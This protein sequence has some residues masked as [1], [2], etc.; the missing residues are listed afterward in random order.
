MQNLY[1]TDYGHYGPKI[2]FAWNPNYFENK[3]VVRGGFASAYN[4]L[5][6]SLFENTVENGPGV[7]QFTPCCGTSTQ[8]FGTPFAGGQ[9]SYV[10]GS[11]SNLNSFKPNPAFTTG[12]AASGFP[13]SAPG[14]TAVPIELYGVG[15]KIR[16]PIS[17]LYSLDTETQMP[18]GVTLTVGYA[19]SVGRHY[20]RLVNQNFLYPNSG[21]VNGVAVSTLASP[22]Y[23]AQTDSSQ[24]YNSLNTTVA[25]RVSHG[26]QFTGTYTW[27]KGMDNIT[28]GDQSDG[29]A[30]QTDPANN[31]LEWAPSDNDVRNRFTGVA[32]YTT[33][34]LTQKKLLGEAVNGWQVGTIVTLLSGF[35]WTPVVNNSVSFVPNA[36]SVNPTRP[37][38]YVAGE[39]PSL[40]GQSCSNGALESGSNFRNRTATSGGTTVFSTAAPTSAATYIPVVG[41]QQRDG[42][43][44]SRC[45]LQRGQGVQHGRNGTYGGGCGSRRT[46]TT[47]STC[48]SFHRSRMEAATRISRIRTSAS[49][50]APDA[51]RVIEFYARLQF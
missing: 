12:I 25:K 39:G 33:P 44:L 42:T 17:Y 2:G 23:L 4:H 40:V 37:I 6:L 11:G 19:G 46:S 7:F 22:E 49:R 28:N 30:N 45:R 3:F 51:G 32:L 35:H 13:N 21:T 34:K 8:D 5:D 16:N 10:H 1:G 20:A 9:I 29:S 24:A 41:A 38:A 15:A 27:S 14:G 47:R 31:R 18:G 48:C 36:S 26:L 50:R 43:L